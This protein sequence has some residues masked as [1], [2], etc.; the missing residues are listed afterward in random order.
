MRAW[1]ALGALL[2]VAVVAV[3]K[4]TPFPGGLILMAS[5]G[6]FFGPYLGAVLGA[7]GSGLSAVLVALVGRA[8]L[9]DPI[10]RRWGG[11]LKP[12]EKPMAED[13][14]NYILACRLFPVV[15]A[16]L[17]NL[18]PVVFP[19]RL[20]SV[21]LATSIGLLPMGFILSS[22]G[23]QVS[24]L[25]QMDEVAATSL[26]TPQIVLPMGA[27]ALL[28]LGPVALKL[29]RRRRRAAREAATRERGV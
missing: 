5:G 23:H 24:T 19:I 11:R 28:S 16:W 1:P 18:L 15:P 7:F 2:Y 13:G 4:V 21:L 17:V 27:L 6:F 12:L 25:A 22:L 10:L 14:F 20:P 29:A 26:L 9:R 3:G 8:I